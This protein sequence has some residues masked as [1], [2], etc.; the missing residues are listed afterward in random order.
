MDR[1]YKD[2]WFKE[3]EQDQSYEMDAQEEITA[4]M[5]ADRAEWERDINKKK[6][7]LATYYSN[8]FAE[9]CL[10]AIADGHH[11]NFS[12][13]PEFMRYAL[14]TFLGIIDSDSDEEV[15]YDGD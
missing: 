15:E 10:T 6:A 3:M 11:L 5:K 4:T 1:R 12:S 9:F 8:K 2:T 13:N 14:D 7:N